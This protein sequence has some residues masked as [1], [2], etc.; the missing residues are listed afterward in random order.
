MARTKQSL[1]SDKATRS[2]S[3]PNGRSKKAGA[4]PRRKAVAADQPAQTMTDLTERRRAEEAIS[5]AAARFEIL[6]TTAGELLQSKE[7]QKIVDALCARVMEHLD[8]HI[9]VNYLV[10]E[11]VGRLHLNACAGLPEQA[12]GAIE[13]LDFGQAIC[14]R[15]AR[16]GRRIVAEDIQESCDPRADLVR[17]LAIRAYACHPI[18][19]MDRVIG[20]VSFGTR[21]RTSFSEDDLAMMKTVTD[22]VATAMERMRAQQELQELNERLELRVQQRT[23]ELLQTMDMVKAER[24]RFRD[25]LDQLPAYLVLLSPDYRVPFANRFFKERFG[26]SE[27]R[28]CYEYLFK[29]TE[30][31]ENCESYKVLKTNAPH[32]W[33]WT[34]P[35][36]R[37]YDIYDFPFTDVDGSPLIMEV[38][39]DITE[40]KQAQAELEK[41]RHHLEELVQARSG[42]LAAAHAE[43]KAVVEHL[44][45]GVV[46]ADLEGHLLQWNRAALEMHGFAS[47]DEARRRLPEFADIFELSTLDG[48]VL[49]LEQWPLAR[50]LRGETLRDWQIRI[51]RHHSDWQ[52]IF[53]YGGELV[54]EMNGRSLLAL[55]TVDDITERKEMEL[56][57]SVATEV[58]RVLNRG[59]GDV[60]G[61]IGEVL[62]LVR[63]LMSFDAVGLRMRRG[64]DCPYYEQNGFS[65]VFVREEDS[66]CARSSDGGVIRDAQGRPIHE[67]TCGLVLSGRTDPTM[68]CFSEGGSF[69]TNGSRELL[70][71]A[72]EADPRTNPRNRCIREGY[73]SIA[74]IPVRSGD[75]IIGLLQLNDRRKERFTP[76]LI[77]FFE[78][79]SDNIGLALQ[80]E[81]ADEAL[82]RT[83]E[84]L[85]RSNLDLE[86][87]AYV[88]SHDL[89]EPLRLVTGYMQLLKQRY[90]GR[91]DATADEFIGFAVEGATRMSQLIKD[92][93]AYSRVGTRGGRF[94]RTECGAV[95]E[96][97]LAGLQ[98]T[99]EE[100]HATVTHDPLPAIRGDTTQLGQLFQNLIGN[101]IKFNGKEPP[102]IHI[103]VRL[104]DEMWEFAVSDNGIGMDARHFERIFMMFQR[105]HSR[106][107]YPGTGIGLTICK[108][109]VERHGGRIWVE[110]RPGEGSTFRFTLP[111]VEE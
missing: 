88:A 28:R 11:D 100:H 91:L 13:W 60:R 51:R 94:R 105:L 21:S 52:R 58:L 74:L 71:L 90:E 26:K 109:I 67:C 8:C 37:S 33:E 20:T 82:R 19:A 78:Q 48:A 102:R 62:R 3:T 32:H 106:E 61:L 39:L 2:I 12:K 87:F 6:S 17:S 25:V 23:A 50:I 38:G 35:D 86:Q 41:H 10:D 15:V 59:G 46:V 29:R 70:E 22:Q 96:E 72:P 7:P 68:P 1:R 66:L 24:Q 47:L 110:S 69:W 31:C 5:R 63:E 77:R 54:R 34:G 75:E 79:L 45:E 97:V 98:L 27:G 92:L 99:I 42:E 16:E 107:Q 36:G 76:E 85:R 103:G 40:R 81:Q 18:I 30:P 89:Q 84:D 14:G 56:R 57:Q 83:A 73:Q 9:F 101:A 93:L 104:V 95:L 64:D 43:M 4:K 111:R 53:S 108:R 80:R 65:D 55:V 49:P 44:D